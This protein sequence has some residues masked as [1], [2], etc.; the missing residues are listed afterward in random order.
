MKTRYCEDT[1][2]LLIEFKP[3]SVAETRDFDENTLLELDSQGQVLAI[4][5]EHA[6]TVAELNIATLRAWTA[7]ASVCPTRAPSCAFANRW[8]STTS[9]R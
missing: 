5:L 4:T 3:D 2:T 1:D 8:S 9:R 6:I 7:S